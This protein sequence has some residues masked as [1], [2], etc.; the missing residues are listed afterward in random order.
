VRVVKWLETP[1]GGILATGSWDKTIKVGLRFPAFKPSF[2]AVPVLGHAN[3]ESRLYG[4]AT[5]ALLHA[6]RLVPAD[7][8]RHRGASC[9][10][11]QSHEPYDS[12]QGAVVEQSSRVAFCKKSCDHLLDNDVA[13]KV[14]N[15][16]N[17]LFP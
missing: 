3:G 10:D 7:G 6:R 17:I 5:R 12:V 11:I 9:P 14:A 4:A 1:Q 2:H 8:S 13:I 16:C 15:A